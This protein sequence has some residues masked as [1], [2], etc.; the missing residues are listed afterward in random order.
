M[1]EPISTTPVEL[2]DAELDAVGGGQTNNNPVIVAGGLI[3]MGVNAVVQASNILNNDLNNNNVEV[4]I[5][6]LGTSIT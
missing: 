1:M 4:A 5:S 2:T 6:V 3:A